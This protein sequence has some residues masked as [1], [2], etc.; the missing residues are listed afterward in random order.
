MRSDLQSSSCGSWPFAVRTSGSIDR[1]TILHAASREGSVSYDEQ[2]SWRR[3][4]L[5]QGRSAWSGRT[6]ELERQARSESLIPRGDP[7]NRQQPYT[8][9]A[10]GASPQVPEKSTNTLGS[11]DSLP[12]HVEITDDFDFKDHSD[13][14][15]FL[16]LALQVKCSLK[17]NMPN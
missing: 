12:G 1:S 10:E 6:F 2:S 4:G 16:A 15:H 14:N 7:S 5:F 13:G 11:A 3:Q 9:A 17:R 8:R